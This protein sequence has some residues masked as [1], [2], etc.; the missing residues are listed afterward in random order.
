MSYV[1][2]IGCGFGGLYAAKKLCK[3]PVQITILDRSNHHLFQPLLYQVAT[4][5]LSPGD[6]AQ[7]IR[8]IFRGQQNVEV[9]LAEVTGVNTNEKKVLLTDGE[10]GYDFLIV[11]AG[12]THAYF[13]HEDWSK[14]APG[15][16]SLEDAVTIRRM[17]LTAFEEAE[18]E[19]NEDRRKVLM[20]FVIVGAGPTGVELAGAMRDIAQHSM[21]KDFRH[22]DSR[23]ARVI[24][25]EGGPRVLP[26]FSEKLSGS[27]QR[28]LEK[29]G[30]EVRTNALVTRV[31]PGYVYIGEER[32]ETKRV[33]WAAGVAAS[34]LGRALGVPLDRAGRVKVQPDLS[35]PDHPEVF[36]IGDLASV[37]DAKGQSV[38]GVA[39][40]AMQMGR[41]AARTILA[42]IRGKQPP[43]PFIYHDKGS[44]ATIG[45]AA[46]VA[47][48]G[49]IQFSGLLA[50][51][52]WLGIH[53]LFLIGFRNRLIVLIQ[54][55]WAYIGFQTGARLI[56]FYEGLDGGYFR[57][58][59]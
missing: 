31:E 47:M 35:I 26:A 20:N 32:I 28:Q 22:I 33:F 16:K 11:A 58:G 53:I 52:A 54:W 43:A 44:L 23:K 15:L 4:A 5:G 2:I 41:Y 3:G 9:L 48:R 1:V 50:W 10:I 29:L 6:I 27:A 25:L 59:F 12:A 38:P 49:N 24:L 30:V 36:V 39:P 7:P 19:T 45:R 34:S 18:K 21:A 14:I 40:A 46:A 57:P 56:T 13:G 55:A 8:S 37:I 42:R 17:F 51:L